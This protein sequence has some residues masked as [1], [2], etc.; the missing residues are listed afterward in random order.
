MNT[1]IELKDVNYEI[2]VEENRKHILKDI[3]LKVEQGDVLTIAGPSGGGKSTMARI[4]ADLISPTSGKVLFK[5][6]DVNEMEPTTY[7]QKVSYAFQQP[8]LFGKTVR[9]NLNF[10]FEVRDKKPD[11]D[12]MIAN[13]KRVNLDETYLDAKVNDLSGGEK[14]RIALLRNVIFIPDVLIL[15]EVTTGLDAENE[16]IVLNLIESLNKENNVTVLMITHIESEISN[17]KNIIHV[18]KGEITNG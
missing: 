3:N 6:K 1:I 8:T 12:V 4:I 11:E 9:E 7:R 10:P 18:E 5:G 2:E 16:K 17:A 14:Q 13:L 15:D